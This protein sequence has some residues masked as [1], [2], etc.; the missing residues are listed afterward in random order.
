M[1]VNYTIKKNQSTGQAKT[2][3]LSV[4]TKKEKEQTF[5]Y[6]AIRMIYRLTLILT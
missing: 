3:I 6:K 1:N 5:T 4:I 2:N